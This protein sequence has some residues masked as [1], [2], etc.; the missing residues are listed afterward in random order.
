MRILQLSL[1]MLSGVFRS[2]AGA[3][4]TGAAQVRSAKASPRSSLLQMTA[5]AAPMA[6]AG[7]SVG[8]GAPGRPIVESDHG[9]LVLP[10]D[11]I[12]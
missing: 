2:T 4:P 3:R 5:R 6:L 7:A 12:R 8:L 10:T 11:A 1:I 9:Q